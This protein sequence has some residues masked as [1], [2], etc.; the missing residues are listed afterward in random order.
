MAATKGMALFTKVLKDGVLEQKVCVVKTVNGTS[1]NITHFAND[2][3][4]VSAANAVQWI[5]AGDPTPTTE[6]ALY[7][8]PLA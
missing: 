4:S 5:D 1:V 6:G 8:Q 3:S 7:V 2:S